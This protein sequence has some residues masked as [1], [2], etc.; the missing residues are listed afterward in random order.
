MLRL[1][2]LIQLS[3]ATLH[4]FKIHCAT[5]KEDPPLEAFFDGRFREWQ[6]H[7]NQRNFPCDEILALI[8]LGGDRWLFAGVYTVLGSPEQMNEDRIWYKYS[9]Q[10]IPGLEHLTGRAIVTFRKDFRASYL[11]GQ[12]YSDHLAVTELRPQRMSIGD[13]PGFNSVRL[14]YRLLSIVIREGLPSWKSPLSSVSGVYVITDTSSGK[15]YVGSA[16]G[17]EGIWQRWLSYVET[18]H[19]GNKE[20]KELLKER[21]KDYVRNFQYALLEVCDLNTNEERIISRETHWKNVLHSREFGYN[22]N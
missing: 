10:E 9:T 19:R 17:G 13:F 18:G 16:G 3:G 21:G 11:V 8:H 7:Q 20:L 14:T 15:H 5:G 1:T 12:S 22:S 6:E 4:H 2:D